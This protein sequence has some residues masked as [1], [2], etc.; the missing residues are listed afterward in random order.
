MKFISIGGNDAKKFDNLVQ[1]NPAFVK[2]YS[3]Q[4]GHCT[5][6]APAWDDL[7]NKLDNHLDAKIH[8]IEVHAEAIPKIKSSCTSNIQGFPTIMEVKPGGLM[9]KEY[10]GNRE[11]DDM[12]DFVVNE[13]INGQMDGIVNT[14]SLT[15][16][17]S[18]KKRSTKKRSTKKR[19]AKK[20][21]TK[22]RN[23]KKRSTKKRSAKKRSAKK[24][25]SKKGGSTGEYIS[26]IDNLMAAALEAPSSAGRFKPEVQRSE[27]QPSLIELAP[28]PDKREQPSSHK[29]ISS[30]NKEDKSK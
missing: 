30:D 7:S 27:V 9:G 6:M 11:A 18:T 22:K 17:R 19:S 28:L 29:E 3:P 24:R 12:A 25:R 23:T 5:A 1:T 14:E 15:K 16:K 13:L 10:N 2:F 20:R 4:C 26:D 21:S 8:I